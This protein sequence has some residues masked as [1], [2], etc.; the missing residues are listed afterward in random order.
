MD[1]KGKPE[2]YKDITGVE[3]DVE[4]IKQ[5]VT[6]LK[7]SDIDYEFRTTLLPDF[8]T[9]ESM[10]KIGEWL[11][12]SKKMVIQKFENSKPLVKKEYQLKKQYMLNDYI[13]FREL[14]KP[15]FEEV[16]LNFLE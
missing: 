11:K 12:G 2:D 6:I 13:N 8:H 10:V 4:K 14:L 7:G 16:K 9:E 15:Y 5:S 3:V 1:I